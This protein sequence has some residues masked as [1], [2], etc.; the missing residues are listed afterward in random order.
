MRDWEPISTAP[1]NG[2]L[3][4]C[5]GAG[6]RRDPLAFLCRRTEGGWTLPATGDVLLIQPTHWRAAAPFFGNLDRRAVATA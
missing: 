3:E 5:L 1:F 4:L 2:D 6:Q